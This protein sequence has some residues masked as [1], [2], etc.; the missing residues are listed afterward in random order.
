VEFEPYADLWAWPQFVVTEKVEQS[1][2]TG[3]LIRARVL[4]KARFI[5]LMTWDGA[6]NNTMTGFD[7]I[8]ANGEWHTA[9]VPF[10]SYQNFDPP[11]ADVA[12]VKKLS[13]GITTEALK[14]TVEISDL[15]LVGEKQINMSNE[16]IFDTAGPARPMS[17]E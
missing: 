7:I 2:V 10:A 16:T 13:I 3:V 6:G 5:R 8:P 11:T 15:Y 9:Y 1:R 12:R 14:N 4:E 17:R